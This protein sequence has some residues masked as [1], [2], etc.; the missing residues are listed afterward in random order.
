MQGDDIPD[1]YVKTYL[2]PDRSEKN[3]RKTQKFK[4]NCNPVYEETLEYEGKLHELLRT[5]EVQVVSKKTFAPNPI[6]GMESAVQSLIQ[7]L[8]PEDVPV[9]ED[10]PGQAAKPSQPPPHPAGADRLGRIELTL[11]Y[12]H[13]KDALEVTV[14]RVANLPVQGDDI[15]DPYV[16]TYLLPDKSESNKRKT[17]KFKDECNPV[18]EETFEYK[19]KQS[20][21]GSRTL[22][23]QVVSKKTF[24]WNPV[25]G[26]KHINLRGVNLEAEPPS[27]STWSRRSDSTRKRHA[28]IRATAVL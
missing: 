26:M 23:V 13:M 16:K 28:P 5:L 15:P 7:D 2:L 24:G 20:D 9:R 3:K 1:P 10:P 14:H 25:L 4:D 19:G 11:R 12:S 21:V 22:E 27:G 17:E 8:L 18:Y 6:L